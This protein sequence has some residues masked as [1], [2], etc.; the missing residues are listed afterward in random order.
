MRRML[1]RG[2]NI[3]T[4][5]QLLRSGYI[6][7]ENG[8]IVEISENEVLSLNELELETIDLDNDFSV[9]PGMIDLHI[10]GAMGSD[11]MDGTINALNKISKALVREGTTSFLATT[12]TESNEEIKKALSNVATYIDHHQSSGGA[13][14]LGAHLE[15]PFLSVKC[16]GAQSEKYIQEPSIDKFNEYQSLANGHIKLVTLAPEIPGGLELTKYLTENGIVASIGHSNASYE[17][18]RMAI[19]AGAR[20]ITHLFNGMRGIHH[21]DPGVTG[22]GLIHTELL[23]EIIADGIHVHPSMVKLA[24]DQKGDEGLVLVTDS[25]RA[26]CLGNGAYLLGE[27]EVTVLGNKAFLPDGTLAGSTL[28]M[29]DA[30]KNIMNYTVSNLLGIVKMTSVNPAKQLNIYDR[31]GSLE[32]GKDADIVILDD[33]YDIYMTI[34]KGIVVFHKEVNS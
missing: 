32:A 34:C 26:K 9:L 6:L 20:H 18:V 11:V 21:R 28:R 3:F 27:Q 23:C 13:E 4:G 12:L 2:G 24:Y 8:I 1:I 19:G 15:G 31:K 10:H 22:A 30:V 16:R 33:S 5:G 14:I 29:I 17:E 25:M 7:V